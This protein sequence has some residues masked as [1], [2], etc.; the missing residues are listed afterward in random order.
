MNYSA[1]FAQHLNHMWCTEVTK[2]RPSAQV[3]ID[4]SRTLIVQWTKCLWW[5][6]A[7]II[8][9][10]II[11]SRWKRFHTPASG[12]VPIETDTIP[13]WA[14]THAIWGE[15]REDAHTVLHCWNRWSIC[16]YIGKPLHIHTSLTCMLRKVWTFSEA[17]QSYCLKHWNCDYFLSP[18]AYLH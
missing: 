14:S 15:S 7:K 9:M 13:M 2:N 12:P 16:A 18:P 8:L 6:I 5:I 1:K 11:M 3:S 10:L 4:R 17:V